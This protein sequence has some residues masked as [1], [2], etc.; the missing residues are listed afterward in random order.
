MSVHGAAVAAV[1]AWFDEPSPADPGRLAHAMAGVFA[2]VVVEDH[3]GL[4]R[5]PVGSVVRDS[6]GLV[7]EAV[8]RDREGNLWYQ[9][10]DADAIETGAISLPAT[11]IHQGVES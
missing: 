4:D 7:L 1:M 8:T 5:L 9:T 3:A 2:P 10:G 11:V 6:A